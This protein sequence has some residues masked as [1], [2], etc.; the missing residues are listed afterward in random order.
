MNESC[1]RLVLMY[2]T[3]VQSLFLALVHRYESWSCF[4]MFLLYEAKMCKCI[5]QAC[6]SHLVCC[7]Q[8][9]RPP[10]IPG[11]DLQSQIFVQ[12]SMLSGLT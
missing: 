8:P 3:C 11:F 5:S 6:T 2:G 7:T 4:A 12:G 1:F 10:L 9:S